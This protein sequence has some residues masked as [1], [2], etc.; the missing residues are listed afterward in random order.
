MRRDRRSGAAEEP[1]TNLA[2]FA[3]TVANASRHTHPVGTLAPNAWGFYDMRGNVMEWCADWF[4]AYSADEKT[5]PVRDAP[6]SCRVV[7]GGSF[8]DSDE[9]CRCTYRFFLAPNSKN[10]VAGFRLA[11]DVAANERR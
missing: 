11:R 10:A 8:I 4:G 3:W 7:R 2:R 9:E 5:D 6:T 1:E